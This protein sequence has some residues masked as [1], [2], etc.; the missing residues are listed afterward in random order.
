MSQTPKP[1]PNLPPKR[2]PR[3]HFATR[4]RAHLAPRDPHL[5]QKGLSEARRIGAGEHAAHY[6]LVPRQFV[7]IRVCLAPSPFRRRRATLERYNP[8][9]V[10]V[11]GHDTANPPKRAD[12]AYRAVRGEELD[13]VPVEP[14][15]VRHLD[16]PAAELLFQH[17]P[18]SQR[19]RR[20]SAH[21]RAQGSPNDPMC[22]KKASAVA[23]SFLKRTR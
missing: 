14:L 20:A 9:S 17:R 1:L 23:A 6:D 2:L 19:S 22:S 3:T 13:I 4:P 8:R 21:L 5:R 16:D 11:V 18:G 12:V 7:E 10:H 15:R